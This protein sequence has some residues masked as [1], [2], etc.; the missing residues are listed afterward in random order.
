MGHGQVDVLGGVAAGGVELDSTAADPAASL[1]GRTNERVRQTAPKANAAT[2]TVVT[3]GSCAAMTGWAILMQDVSDDLFARGVRFV[4][5]IRPKDSIPSELLD[6][7]ASWSYEERHNAS[8]RARST[9]PGAAPG[10][11]ATTSTPSASPTTYLG[12]T[13]QNSSPRP[14]I[15][16]IEPSDAP[17]RGAARTR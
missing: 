16:P 6:G 17:T 14:Q 9:S 7:T 1:R 11:G 4:K 3:T 5:E 10:W 13:F 15:V 2:E 8:A 12:Q